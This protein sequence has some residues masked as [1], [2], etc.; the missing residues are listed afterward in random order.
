MAK[1]N[2]I[3][4]DISVIKANQESVKSCL[5]E[6]KSILVKHS[7]LIDQ[8]SDVIA[9]HAISRHDNEIASCQSD[10]Q[11][12]IYIQ[13]QLRIDLDLTNNK[14]TG[15]ALHSGNPTDHPSERNIKILNHIEILDRLRR[16]HN[17]LVRGVPENAPDR[18]ATSVKELLCSIDTNAGDQ[19]LDIDRVGK[20]DA[21]LSV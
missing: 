11:T 1:L 19:C 15:N 20:T 21:R 7:T 4:T 6:Y 18:D 5:A 13:T 16:S 17:V 14:V 12:V 3:S 10:I 2:G 8:D 9:D